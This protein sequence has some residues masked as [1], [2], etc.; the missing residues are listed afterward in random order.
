M[1]FIRNSLLEEG[2]CLSLPQ[3]FSATDLFVFLPSFRL[4]R[5][6]FEEIANWDIKP[7]SRLSLIDYAA[8]SETLFPIQK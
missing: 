3:S 6:I 1:S 5:G 7:L 8:I 4:N 2:S